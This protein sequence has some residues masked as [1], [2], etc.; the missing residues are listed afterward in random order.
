MDLSMKSRKKAAVSR[1]KQ[2]F[3]PVHFC[4]RVSLKRCLIAISPKTHWA[5][6]SWS[7][8]HLPGTFFCNAPKWLQFHNCQI[9]ALT[10]L[11]HHSFPISLTPPKPVL[12]PALKCM[13]D[14]AFGHKVWLS[15]LKKKNSF[16]ECFLGL[17]FLEVF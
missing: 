15:C 11:Q 4:V 3:H 6:Y 9:T 12:G 5:L 1:T 10:A 14:R 16:S 2:G 8:K 13:P 17:M 7:S